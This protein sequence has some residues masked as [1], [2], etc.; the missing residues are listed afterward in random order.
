MG[1]H[2][3]QVSF[4]ADEQAPKGVPVARRA[5]SAATARSAAKNWSRSSGGTTCARAGPASAFKRCCMA[6][7]RFD[8][9]PRGD[10]RRPW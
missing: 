2:D 6:S 3:D 5:S 8:G 1:T 7:G 10:Y 9:S 4:W